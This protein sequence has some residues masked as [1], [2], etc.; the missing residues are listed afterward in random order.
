MDTTIVSVLADWLQPAGLAIS[1]LHC[2]GDPAAPRLL[3]QAGA[4]QHVGVVP[5][6]PPWTPVE[7]LPSLADRPHHDRA[8]TTGESMLGLPAGGR[9]EGTCLNVF[10]LSI[11]NQRTGVLEVVSRGPLSAP[12]RKL[13]DGLL[14][15]YRNQLGLLDYSERDTLTGLLNRRTF[16]EQFGKCMTDDR[17]RRSAAPAAE[18][19]LLRHWLG[20]IDIDHFKRVN[21][22]FGHL[23]GDEVLLLVARILRT[24]FRHGDRLYRFGGEEFVVLLRAPSRVGAHEAFDRFRAQMQAFNFPQVGHVTA[25]LGFTELRTLDT[26]SAAFERA[27]R[28]VYHAKEHGRNRIDCHEALVESG[29]FEAAEKVGDVELF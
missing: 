24:A 9:G 15:I 25:S 29:A 6:D 11:G 17:Q 13:V 1:L 21:D 14:L 4:R 2:V 10:P 22:Q 3:L 26:A 5:G 19:C 7:A 8:L 18:P 12:Q 20:V 27:D 23:I 28:A 16:D